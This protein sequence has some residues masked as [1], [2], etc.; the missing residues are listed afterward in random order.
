MGV[1]CESGF[2]NGN[3]MARMF[4]KADLSISMEFLRPCPRVI[5]AGATEFDGVFVY[6]GASDLDEQIRIVVRNDDYTEL[7]WADSERLEA[8][9]LQYRK[10]YSNEEVQKKEPWVTATIDYE[11]SDGSAVEFNEH[12]AYG[13]MN[14][15]WD[16]SKVQDDYYEIRVV[17]MCSESGH[18]TEDLDSSS[19]MVLSGVIDRTGPSILSGFSEPT[20]DEWE[21]R[22]A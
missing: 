18:A 19:T 20:D 2:W 8:I 1:P 17:A 21:V 10:S 15:L 7:S 16:T 13:F 3:G 5:F 12:D 9:T 11:L 22:F 6:S 4:D 14:L